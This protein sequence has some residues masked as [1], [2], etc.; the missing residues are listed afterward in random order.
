MTEGYEPALPTV[1]RA[2]AAFR[3]EG[4]SREN[5]A[6]SW[7]SCQ[8]AM[9]LWDDGACED[10]ASGLCRVARQRGGLTL[11]PFALNYSA[12]HQLFLGEFGIAEQ[13]VREAEAITAATRNH[14]TADFSVLLAAW[15]GERE[16]TEALRAGL[17]AA[18]TERGEGFAVEVAEWAGA[19]LHNGLGEYTEAAAAAERAYDPD[20]L[21][22]GV[23]VLP[24]LIEAA[25]RSGDR[26]A[27]EVA[28]ER[29]VERSSTS[30]TE[31]ARGVE[32]AARAL[33]TE[34][35]AAEELYLE[36]IEHLGRSRVIVLHARAQLTYGEWLRRENRRVDA[37]EQLKA[38]YAA[39]EAMGAQG[40]ADRARRE[41]LATGE[42]VRKRT[43][44]ARA[45]LT[46][47]EAQI[48]RLA[49]DRLTNPEIA[50]QLYLSPRTVEY[51]L[52]KVFQKLGISSRKE[53][54]N[55]LPASKSVL[56]PA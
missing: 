39:F 38:A 18:G 37:R 49:S 56:I 34:G 41:L 27:A 31:W 36:A 51:H 15:R 8:L 52:R 32:A 23:W 30:T 33:L 45:D 40:F 13:Q 2:L 24:E 7:L 47:Q 14:P 54:A 44:D 6:W 28:F 43:D 48:A 25:V 19:V 5:L 21:G 46:P 26:S 12:A 17:I 9:D 35:P 4:F 50:A 55:A 22:F 20:G 53:L 42:T 3:A 16:R 29:L 1:A 10:I 11:L